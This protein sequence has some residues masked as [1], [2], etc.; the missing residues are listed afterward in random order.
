MLVLEAVGPDLAF[1]APG[2]LQSLGENETS[3]KAQR[4]MWL[5]WAKLLAGRVC[6][7]VEALLSLANSLAG[8]ICLSSQWGLIN[9]ASQ[10]ALLSCL[11]GGRVGC[12]EILSYASGRREWIRSFQKG[13]NRRRPQWSLGGFVLTRGRLSLVPGVSRGFA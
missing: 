6:V 3:N 1:W 10:D 11:G 5:P 13:L 7:G 12:L 9:T 2:R 8:C 4:G